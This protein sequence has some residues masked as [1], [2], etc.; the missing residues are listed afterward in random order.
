MYGCFTCGQVTALTAFVGPFIPL[1]WTGC[2]SSYGAA[3]KD[4]YPVCRPGVRDNIAQTQRAVSLILAALGITA[5]ALVVR[6]ADTPT[7]T[8]FS[9]AVSQVNIGAQHR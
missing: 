3:K 9:E 5:L 2:A 1:L 6:L 8:L 7:S 4:S